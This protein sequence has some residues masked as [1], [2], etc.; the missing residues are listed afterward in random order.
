[1]YHVQSQ[2]IAACPSYTPS[3]THTDTVCHNLHHGVAAIDALDDPIAARASPAPGRL[4]VLV[5]H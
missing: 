2:V 1:M 5:R 4:V 3:C